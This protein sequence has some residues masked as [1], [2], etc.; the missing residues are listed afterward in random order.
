M[1]FAIVVNMHAR[2][3]PVLHEHIQMRAFVPEFVAG[4]LAVVTDLETGMPD[5]FGQG[6]A[7]H[8]LIGAVCRHYRVITINYDERVIMT[9]DQRLQVDGKTDS[10]LGLKWHIHGII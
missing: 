4:F 8:L 5:N 7:E 2:D 9:L 6:L 10:R 1:I 3:L